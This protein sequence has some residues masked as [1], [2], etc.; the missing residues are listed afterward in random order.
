MYSGYL[1]VHFTGESEIGEQ[2]YFSV[3]EDGF[4]WKDLNG[5][6]PVIESKIC[7]M[8]VRDPFILRNKIDGKFY[9]ISTDLRI[10]NGKGWGVAQFEGSKKLMVTCSENL[11]DWSDIWSVDI[12]VENAGCVWAPEAIYDRESGKYMVFFASMVE[13]DGNPPK[14]I[15]YNTFT[16]DFVHFTEPEIYI[17]RDN[18]V[19]DTTIVENDGIYFRFSKDETTKN[20]IADYSKNVAKGPFTRL[21]CENVEKLMGVEGPLGFK[22]NDR[23]EWCV[24]VDRFAAG[25]GYLPIVSKD[26]LSGEFRV[27]EPFEYDMGKTKKRHGSVLNITKEEYDMLCEKWLKE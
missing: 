6:M 20:I 19:I 14:Q 7:E 21:E 11:V 13:K 12:G 27:L 3:S 24:M 1:F 8:G 2:I 9:I 4:N 10:A 18:H 16:E 15:I 5:G 25:L 26:M 23:D 22:F 17:E